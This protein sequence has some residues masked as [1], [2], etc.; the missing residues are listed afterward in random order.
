[1]FAALLA[2][3]NTDQCDQTL[4]QL[5]HDCLLC[6]L[7]DVLWKYVLTQARATL[8]A[9]AKQFGVWHFSFGGRESDIAGEGWA[10]AQET[11]HIA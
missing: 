2:G 11:W 1:M 5:V 9:H 7:H 8:F 4:L 3:I 6:R 10:P